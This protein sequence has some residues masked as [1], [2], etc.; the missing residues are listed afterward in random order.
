MP[1]HVDSSNLKSYVQN[2]SWKN[3]RGTN[4]LLKQ[5]VYLISVN[6]TNIESVTCEEMMEVIV[7]K[8]VL[9]NES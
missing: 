8:V 1:I 6:E 2:L 3:D 9:C 5:R 7:I 4:L